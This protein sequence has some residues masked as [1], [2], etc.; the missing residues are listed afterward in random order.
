[1]SVLCALFSVRVIAQLLQATYA[2][3]WIPAFDAWHSG[4]LPYPI[5]LAAQVS[6]IGWMSFVLN[7]VR[8]QTIRPRRW[9]Y[10]ACLIFGGSYFAFMSFR[11][12]AGM[13]FLAENAWF[14]R[15]IPAFFH[16]VIAG[17]ILLLGGHI[18]GRQRNPN[19]FGSSS[20]YRP[21]G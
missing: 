12:I 14:S 19:L 2:V 3:D 16:L 18:R 8:N 15:T 13:T 20:R 6:I 1:M 10:R 17:F 5:L 21:R 4:A 9:K 11:W 7:K